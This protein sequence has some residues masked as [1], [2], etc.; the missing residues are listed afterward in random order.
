MAL[1]PMELESVGNILSATQTGSKNISQNTWTAAMAGI[2]IPEA[3]TYLVSGSIE[4]QHSDTGN[5]QKYAA[6]GKSNS[7]ASS[8]SRSFNMFVT[9]TLQD[10]IICGATVLDLDANDY[11][12]VGGYSTG[13]TASLLNG[14]I[15]AIK[16]K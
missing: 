6:I 13:S 12:T 11:V 4:L 3:G 2:K 7:S 14:T 8:F 1:A 15:K 16:I 5:H 9:T 10:F